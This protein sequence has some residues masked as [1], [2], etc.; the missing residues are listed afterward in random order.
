MGEAQGRGIPFLA[1]Q[2]VLWL[3]PPGAGVALGEESGLYKYFA[4]TNGRFQ[5]LH[6]PGSAHQSWEPL[7]GFNRAH[8]EDESHDS[9]SCLWCL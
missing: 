8:R 2:S 6:F 3:R 4:F 1:S 5:T 9:H 7:G